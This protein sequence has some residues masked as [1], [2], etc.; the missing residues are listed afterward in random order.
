MDFSSILDTLKKLSESIPKEIGGLDTMYIAIGAVVVLM[1]IWFL[2]RPSSTSSK[3]EL[4][5]IEPEKVEDKIEES[6]QEE[7]NSQIVENS[8]EI[9]EKRAEPET[10]KE[11]EEKKSD[12]FITRT[13]PE[14][15]TVFITGLELSSRIFGLASKIRRV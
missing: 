5:D 1:I 4:L 12:I 2:I 14:N 6:E 13:S 10:E 15:F 11:V 9:E 7:S 3:S 8:V